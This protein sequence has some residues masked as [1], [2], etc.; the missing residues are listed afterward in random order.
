LKTAKYDVN[1]ELVNWQEDCLMSADATCVKGGQKRMRRSTFLTCLALAM[2]T[3]LLA[4]PLARA[5]QTCTQKAVGGSTEA[6]LNFIEPTDE[7]LPATIDFANWLDSIP[8]SAVE[9]SSF[10]GVSTGDIG[11]TPIV[12]NWNIFEDVLGNPELS[13]T[14]TLSLNPVLPGVF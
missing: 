2:L 3:C 6:C 1:Q 10:V 11:P 14:L 8:L 7:T 5:D 9:A 4:P 12:F 13:D